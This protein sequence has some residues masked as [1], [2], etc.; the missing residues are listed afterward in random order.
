MTAEDKR[1]LSLIVARAVADAMPVSRS[2]PLGISDSAAREL[3]SFAETWKSC[4]K[5]LLA[6]VIATAAGGLL[7]VLWYGIKTLLHR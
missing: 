2:C 7:T 6:G 5:N 1:E 3:I 4:R